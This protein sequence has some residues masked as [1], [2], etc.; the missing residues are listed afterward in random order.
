MDTPATYLQWGFIQISVANLLM[1]LGM[2]A[3]F[4]GAIV[5]PFPRHKPA[6]APPPESTDATEAEPTSNWTAKLSRAMSRRWPW[7]TLLPDRQPAFVA[8]WIYL[9]GVGAIA[10]LIWIVASGVILVVF[11][12]V[13]WHVSSTGRF[14]NSIH[15]WSVQ[16][17]FAST[18][19]HLV[20]KYFMAS[21]RHG[22]ALT[23]ITGVVIFAFGAL[24]AF[25]GYLAQ[26]NFDSQ[27]IAA[28]GKDAIN[29]IGAGS[30]FNTLDFSQM[31]GIHVLLL[32]AAVVSLVTVHV[33]LVRLK[34]V[35]RPID[36]PP[37]E[38]AGTTAGK[39]VPGEASR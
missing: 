30:F 23:W 39:A 38:E 24:T 26:Q 12:P 8:S 33:L 16:V 13:W 6:P 20:G 17:F 18:I 29:S 4:V 35:A 2:V 19:V 9:F 10:S 25:T 14:V 27:W 15:F 5:L 7:H 28:E 36:Q 37:P 32:P 31:Y 34:G 21:W 22:R 3:L 1:I 11:G